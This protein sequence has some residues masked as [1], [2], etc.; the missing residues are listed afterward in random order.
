MEKQKV[1]NFLRSILFQL[2][3]QAEYIPDFLMNLYDNYRYSQPPTD[4]LLSTVKHVIIGHKHTFIIIDALDE[5]PKQNEERSELCNLLKDIKEWTATNLHVLFTSRREVDL[6]ESL[7][8]LCTLGPISIQ[9]E[10]VQFDIR[11]FIRA[12]LLRNTRLSAW[13]T[14]IRDEIEHT[15]VEGA[16]GM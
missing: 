10:G 15:L 13:P 12:E 2:I 14:D 7:D 4:L 11:K 8:Q 1:A 5:C 9:G 3:R 16:R 6:V